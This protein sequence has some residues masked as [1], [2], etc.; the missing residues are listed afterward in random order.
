MC[1]WRQPLSTRLML[2]LLA[3]LAL[4]QLK[5]SRNGRFSGKGGSSVP[6]A[7]FQTVSRQQICQLLNTKSF[8]LGDPSR[9]VAY[10]S[11]RSYWDSRVSA[12]GKVF[13]CRRHRLSG[14]RDSQL[15]TT[16]DF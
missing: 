11:E 5:A 7:A 15:C 14:D 12:A 10:S 13:W 2:C 6:L 9:P 8:I 4:A 16:A 1:K 3:Q